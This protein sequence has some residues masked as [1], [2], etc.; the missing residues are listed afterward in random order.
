MSDKP[1]SLEMVTVGGHAVLYAQRVADLEARIRALESA[2]SVGELVARMKGLLLDMQRAS[3]R[4]TEHG[5][6]YTPAGAYL[7]PYLGVM[8]EAIA[9]LSRIEAPAADRTNPTIDWKRTAEQRIEESELLKS[10]MRAA[11]TEIEEH[12]DAHCD[13]EGNGPVNLVRR[14]KLGQHGGGYGTP[15]PKLFKE[16]AEALREAAD[17]E[18]Q[19]CHAAS[20]QGCGECQS[21]LYEGLADSLERLAEPQPAPAGKDEARPAVTEEMVEAALVAGAKAS[22][23]TVWPEPGLSPEELAHTRRCMRAALSA[24]LGEKGIRNCSWTS[25]PDIGVSVASQDD[26]ST[27]TILRFGVVTEK[28]GSL[29]FSDFSI[30]WNYPTVPTSYE[31][32]V[33]RAVIAR[34]QA[35]YEKECARVS[36]ALVRESVS[37]GLREMGEK[38]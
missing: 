19:A 3:Y 10:I 14:L 20:H 2:P 37:A 27:P 17:A 18:R 16:C 7:L 28:D 22:G 8:R 11:A 34:L 31:C 1:L 30:D 21:A 4:E 12:W 6:I 24:A 23:E 13:T 26:N 29:V 36:A 33:L 38:G 32:I 35:E 5:A 25:R 15:W 9:A